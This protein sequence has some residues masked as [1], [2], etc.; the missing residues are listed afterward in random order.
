ML[1]VAGHFTLA[2][3]DR[4]AFVEAK[5]PSMLATRQEP[6][7]HAY[8]ISADPTDA[9]RVALFERWEDQAALDAHL[10]VLA[11]AAPDGAPRP[12]GFEVKIYDVAGVRDFGR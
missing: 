2:A 9:T 4:D 1:I 3:E 8:V 7:C 12:Q 10:G 5:R 6:G 11:A